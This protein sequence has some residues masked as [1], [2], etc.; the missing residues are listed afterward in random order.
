M[1]RAEQFLGTIRS[2][3]VASRLNRLHP[4]PNSTS[5]WPHR[6][7]VVL[8]CATFPLIWVGGL[9]TTTQAGMAVEDWPTTYGYNLFLYPWQTWLFGPWDLFI[10][11]GH[12]L[13]GAFVGI[14]TLALLVAVWRGDSRRWMR[15]VAVAAVVGVTLQGVVG[16]LRVVFNERWLARLHG[17]TGPLFFALC[18]AICVFTSSRWKDA[19]ARRGHPGA[20]RLQAVA[21]VTV[22]LA[23]VQIVLGAHLRHVELTTG[24]TAFSAAVFLHLATAALVVLHVVLLAVLVARSF[25]REA[26]LTGPVAWLTAMIGLQLLLGGAT[27]VLKYGWPSATGESAWTAGH[28]NI[29]GSMLQAAVVT[30][31]M[32]L[33]SLILGLAV[34][35]TLRAVRGLRPLPSTAPVVTASLAVLA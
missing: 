11:H 30:G 23:Y 28:T 10:E 19:R 32:A 21:L 18:V 26:D 6:L 33:G 17:C 15:W 2:P 9:V 20:A 35:A 5:P 4:N 3:Q 22:L 1:Q 29:S 7:A 14:L 16:G 31:H 27:W 25:R 24:P 13:F 12:R 8:T 34:L